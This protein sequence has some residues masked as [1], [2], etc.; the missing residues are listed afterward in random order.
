MVSEII[1]NDVPGF[2]IAFVFQL[3]QE[4]KEDVVANRDHPD[5]WG[6]IR[7]MIP[8]QGKGCLSLIVPV[9]I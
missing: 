6:G 4:E 5:P 3:T 2:Y 1:R 9:R 8:G 7:A